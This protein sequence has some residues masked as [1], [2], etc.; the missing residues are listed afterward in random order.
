MNKNRK[1]CCS[2]VCGGITLAIGILLL[3]M[4]VIIVDVIVEHAVILK[5]GT[6]AYPV[7][8]EVPVPFY[9]QFWIWDL[10][11]PDEFLLGAK[12]RLEQK[13]PYTWTEYRPKDEST[14]VHNDNGTVTFRNKKQFIFNRDMS[15]GPQ[16]D[17]VTTINIA[18]FAVAH[19]IR[20]QPRRRKALWNIIHQRSGAQPIVTTTVEEILWGYEDD[21]LKLA[22]ELLGEDVIPLTHFGIMLG[23]NNSD[24]GL[25]NVFTGE[26]DIMKV[27][28]IEKWNGMTELPY[29]TTPE[30]RMINGTDGTVQ[31]PFVKKEETFY[32]FIPLACRTGAAVYEEDRKYHRVPVLHYVQPDWLFASPDIN[33]DNIGFCVPDEFTCPPSGLVNASVCFFHAPVFL[34]TPHFLYTEQSVLDMV[35]GMAPNKEEHQIAVDVEPISGATMKGDIRAQVNVFIRDYDFVTG[36][37]T[38]PTAYFPILWQNESAGVPE[39]IA[40]E[41][42][43]KTRLPL[44]LIVVITSLL[45][46]GGIGLLVWLG[47][48]LYD[49]N[50][51]DP[52][53]VSNKSEHALEGKVNPSVQVKDEK[54]A[55]HDPYED[56]QKSDSSMDVL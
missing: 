50:K 24:D 3:P 55:D 33:P 23:Q 12:P 40:R 22:Q 8:V 37:E 16:T 21:Y 5:P 29:W 7:W 30:A 4:T 36:L 18:V 13:G 48:L 19:I 56:I 14:I 45:L 52:K 26:T 15:V 31:H 54:K 1:I 46:V 34:S 51:Q 43:L 42:F 47:I 11:N 49:K 6:I 32:A 38:I 41:Y 39:D 25:W 44:I 2:S 9:L 20:Y 28:L 53:M 10:Q 35:E 27:N 17:T